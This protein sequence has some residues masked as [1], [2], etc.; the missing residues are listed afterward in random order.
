MRDNAEH[1]VPASKNKYS[2]VSIQLLSQPVLWVLS[3]HVS[4]MYLQA[5]LCALCNMGSA[6]TLF[7]FHE[8][9][10]MK[11]QCRCTSYLLYKIAYTNNY[12]IYM[13][14]RIIEFTAFTSIDTGVRGAIVLRLIQ[15]W[16]NASSLTTVTPLAT[17][18]IRN[19]NSVHWYS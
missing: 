10:W 4:Y 2:T 5:A 17:C 13:Y 12:A 3:C 15:L 8:L 11:S 9:R 16:N 18:R 6:C 7:V 14:G 1:F 19:S